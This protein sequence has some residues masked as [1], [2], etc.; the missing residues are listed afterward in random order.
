MLSF[1]SFLLVLLALAPIQ[2]HAFLNWDDIAN[3]IKINVDQRNEL[4][5]LMI[6]TV[7]VVLLIVMVFGLM[8]KYLLSTLDFAMSPS[9]GDMRQGP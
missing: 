3:Y 1:L 2:V 7:F 6:G 8:G 4:V 9:P 5:P